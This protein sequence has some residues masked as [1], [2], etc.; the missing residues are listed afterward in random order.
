[1]KNKR[2]VGKQK[3]KPVKISLFEDYVGWEKVFVEFLFMPET[4]DKKKNTMKEKR[5][6]NWRFNKVW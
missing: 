3:I 2:R 5:E 6:R 1:M 4:N